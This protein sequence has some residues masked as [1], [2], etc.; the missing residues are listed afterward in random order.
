MAQ[1][2]EEVELDD[3][4]AAFQPCACTSAPHMKPQYTEAFSELPAG[5]LPTVTEAIPL[6]WVGE[7][8]SEILKARPILLP[9]LQ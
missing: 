9:H 4:Q 8:I 7:V 5:L 6:I 2:K 1:D 3:P